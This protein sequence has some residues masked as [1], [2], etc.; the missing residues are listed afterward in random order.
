MSTIL[1]Q[2]EPVVR[3]AGLCR[4]YPRTSATVDRSETR[5]VP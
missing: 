2:M 4:N 1:E 5:A 3:R